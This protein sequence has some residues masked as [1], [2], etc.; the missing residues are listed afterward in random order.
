MEWHV[1]QNGMNLENVPDDL[2]TETI[3]LMAVVENPMAIRYAVQSQKLVDF[4][5][6]RDHRVFAWIDDE[7]KTQE[8]CDSISLFE[9]VEAH[10][11]EQ[12]K[13]PELVD[14]IRKYYIDRGGALK[15]IE[16]ATS[17]RIV[18]NVPKYTLPRE[19]ESLVTS[20]D[21]A[22]FDYLDM[23]L[24]DIVN[25][26]VKLK[27]ALFSNI[28]DVVKTTGMC[29]AAVNYDGMQL[30]NI[31]L[32]MITKDIVAAAVKQNP[33]VRNHISKSMLD[34]FSSRGTC[35]DI[36]NILRNR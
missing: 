35:R 26:A 19:I 9:G 31:P 18:N 33:D 8:M 4:A 21:L 6:S 10:I 15:R 13:T 30:L 7:F 28:L 22:V 1:A 16:N 29:M 3:C 5:L 36:V 17:S 12:Y 34:Y 25:M 32:S 20:S 11:P 14:K 24:L 23:T 27:P 2:K